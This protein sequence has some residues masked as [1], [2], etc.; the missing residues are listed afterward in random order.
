MRMIMPMISTAVGIMI[1]LE[2]EKIEVQ[3]D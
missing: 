2:I 3:N 1:A